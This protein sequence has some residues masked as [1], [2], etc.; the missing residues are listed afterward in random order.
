MTHD[1]PTPPSPMT[2]TL[3]PAGT[4]A[5]LTTAP[6]PVETQQPMSAAIAGST[7][8]GRAIAA[9]V[10]TTAAPAI[11]PIPQYD[12]TGS[13]SSVARTVAPSG[14]RWRNDGESGQAH[15][16]PPRHDRQTPHGTSHDNATGWPR[17]RLVDTGADRLDDAGPLVAHHD[18]RGPRPL[19]VA[20]MEVGVADARG[21]HPDADLT[22][23]RL[24][25]D[26]VLDRRRFADRA[27]DG[28]ARVPSGRRGRGHASARRRRSVGRAGFVGHVGG[29]PHRVVD[30]CLDVGLRP[31]ERQPGDDGLP[32]HGDRDRPGD[33]PQVVHGG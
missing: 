20:D 32:G 33:R 25:D 3:A 28:A 26:Q 15:G 21:E 14:I 2:A 4:A 11:V 1:R 10:G 17:R 7:P 6:T 23:S 30:Q 16:R 22:G 8:S 9:S 29:P 5:V 12:R 13:P 18:R 31:D 24:G 27:Q 19:P